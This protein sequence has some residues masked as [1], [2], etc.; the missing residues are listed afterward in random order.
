MRFFYL[1][2]GKAIGWTSKHYSQAYPKNYK[3]PA[4]E[5]TPSNGN[6]FLKGLT[7]NN[8]YLLLPKSFLKVIETKTVWSSWS[9][10][11]VF[12]KKSCKLPSLTD[13]SLSENFS[14]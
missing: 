1:K 13:R 12:S 14:K 9:L 3:L 4:D 5:P 7:K 8:D 11:L 6:G 2:G 10:V